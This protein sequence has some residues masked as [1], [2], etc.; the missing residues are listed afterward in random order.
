VQLGSPKKSRTLTT[1]RG[2]NG[3]GGVRRQGGS[4]ARTPAGRL[5]DV[6]HLPLPLPRGPLLE[7]REFVGPIDA[8][9]FTHNATV[10]GGA[11]PAPLLNQPSQ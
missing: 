10:S 5:A 3:L 11:G 8:T 2:G 6:R 4:P 1:A 9:S 7:V